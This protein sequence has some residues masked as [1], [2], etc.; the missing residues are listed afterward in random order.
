MVYA[1]F[2]LVH[3]AAAR[4]LFAWLIGGGFIEL[5]HIFSKCSSLKK[6]EMLAQLLK[7]NDP[8]P[9]KKKT[10]T[11]KNPNQTNKQT[12]QNNNNNNNKNTFTRECRACEH[13]V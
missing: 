11:K 1:Q 6:E 3:A 12:K 9:Q 2:V 5:R 13:V 8:P 10:K 7:Y 4:L